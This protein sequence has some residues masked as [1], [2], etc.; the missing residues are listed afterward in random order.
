VKVIKIGGISLLGLL[1]FHITSGTAAATVDAMREASAITCRQGVSER[2][3]LRSTDRLPRASGEARVE[4]QGGT[5]NIEVTLDRM[6]PALLFG[7][8]YNTYVLWV[9]SPSGQM[10][11]LGEL[12]LVGERSQLRATTAATSLALLVTAEPHYL[13]RAPSAFIVLESKSPPEATTI[14]FPVIE[15]VYNFERATLEGVKSARGK[16]DTELH[17]AFTSFRLAQ[18]ANAHKLAP[19]EFAD[20]ER[21]L[22][23]TLSLSRVGMNR[24]EISAQAR[25][26]VRLAVA[27]QRL[28]EDRAFQQARVQRKVWEEER[29][30]LEGPAPRGIAV[31]LI[32][33]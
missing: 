27:S 13:V 12:P 1:A 30:R 32:Q 26:T 7:G 24:I 14:P 16:V 11:N 3:P 8:D 6:K 20:A 15:G 9:V 23:E 5:T 25:E 28:A 18:R 10:E 19:R 2:V 29:A 21:A 33:P 17:Q 22:D 31:E 4:R